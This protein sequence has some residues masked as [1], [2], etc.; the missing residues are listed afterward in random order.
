MS[1]EVTMMPKATAPGLGSVVRLVVRQF[2]EQKHYRQL[3]RTLSDQWGSC[4]SLT[5]AVKL[6]EAHGVRIPPEQEARF[7]EMKEDRMI[8]AL[9][10]K[11]PQQSRE[12]F[13]HF[14]LQLSF[15]ASTTTRL[16][17]A[18]ENGQPEVVEEALESAENVGVLPY[19]MKMAIAQ[20]GQ[21]VKSVAGEHEGWLGDTEAKM[22][23]LL[24]AASACMAMQ[25]ELEEA[26]AMLTTYQGDSKDKAKSVLLGI[27]EGNDKA[28][29][30][31]CVSAWAAISQRV[32]R[33]IEIRKEYEEEIEEANKKLFAYKSKQLDQVKKVLNRTAGEAQG[34][35]IL[36]CLA[37][38]KTEA[39]EVRKREELSKQ[40]GELDHSLK[41]CAGAAKSKAEAVLAR[42]NAGNEEGL[43]QNAWKAWVI[44]CEEYK[45]NKEEEDALKGAEAKLNEFM[46]NQK[47]GAKSV[48]SRMTQA[49]DSGLLQTAFTGWIEQVEEEKKAAELEG[50]MSA[51]AAKF[52]QFGIKNKGSA[53]N[54]TER[55]AYLQDQLML[56]WSFQ[57]WKREYRT[58]CMRRFGKERNDKRKK[59]LVGVKGLF[60]DFANNL[61]TTL[62]SGTPRVEDIKSR[63]RT[64]AVEH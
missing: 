10:A 53:M 22:S 16:R 58:E 26:K 56:V 33:E 7:L 5:A 51:K 41:N 8:E 47:E 40:H 32:K 11:M 57:Q 3:H 19:L 17:A 49:N 20:A 31:S 25:K 39:R 36:N 35:L 4:H 50:E 34:K 37:A 46:Q 62:N 55:A 9:V 1:V 54:A 61:E 44:F 24:Q 28:L 21:E 2:L 60:K 23:P 30:G 63:S 42:M 59:E 29:V 38:L 64:R 45:K 12:Q 6:M 52:S 43:K 27:A 48:L 13:E 14:F 15:I 18:L